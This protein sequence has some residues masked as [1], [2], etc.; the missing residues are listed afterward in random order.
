MR[1]QIRFWCGPISLVLLATSLGQAAPTAEPEDLD[2]TI[3]RFFTS[4]DAFPDLLKDARSRVEELYILRRESH[5]LESPEE[6]DL[7]G[8]DKLLTRSDVEE[9]LEFL[10]RTGRADNIQKAVLLKRFLPD[11]NPLAQLYNSADNAQMIR[12]AAVQL[13]GY[14]PLLQLSASRGGR[15]LLSEGLRTGSVDEIVREAEEA[16]PTTSL[17][18]MC[19]GRWLYT[20]G[21]LLE[22][23]HSS[24]G[25][26]AAAA[27]NSS[28]KP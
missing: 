19:S 24:A 14:G 22:E 18:E 8:R 4:R 27:G 1:W 17:G 15:V 11:L 3:R 16:H 25:S 13:G 9:L 10:R 28:Q 26:L 12:S 21:D 5:A 20:V 7:Y 2:N 23:L 6:V